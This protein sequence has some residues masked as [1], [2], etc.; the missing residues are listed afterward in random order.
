MGVWEEDAVKLEIRFRLLISIYFP[1]AERFRVSF[2]TLYYLVLLKRARYIRMEA[3]FCA[4]QKSNGWY[5]S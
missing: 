3:R 1:F 5:R 4:S 2:R